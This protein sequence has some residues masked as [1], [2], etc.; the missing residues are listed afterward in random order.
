MAVVE[1]Q[2]LPQEAVEEDQEAPV[3]AEDLVAVE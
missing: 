1:Q 2:L 3:V